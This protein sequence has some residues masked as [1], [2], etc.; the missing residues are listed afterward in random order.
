MKSFKTYGLLGLLTICALGLFKL[1][2]TQESELA[3]KED[4]A[5]VIQRVKK[6]PRKNSLP[7]LTEKAP[8]NVKE[9]PIHRDRDRDRE[10]LS[11]QYSNIL[12][13]I[14]QG[15][16]DVDAR[17]ESGMTL[18]MQALDYHR[19]QLAYALVKRGADLLSSDKSG[20]DILTQA[21][22]MGETKITQMALENGA[23][24]N[25]ELDKIGS[26]L[27]M[28]AA[29]EGLNEQVKLLIEY[30][31]A[32]NHQNQKGETALMWASDMG[33]FQTAQLLI[34]NK[35]DKSLKNHNALT[36]MEMAKNRG[37]EKLAKLL[38]P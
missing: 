25:K 24:P 31:A 21:L 10:I 34:K 22:L 38:K 16:L 14:D 15:E 35:A 3:P 30:G 17:D 20:T 8:N 13:R 1:R 29:Q 26:A 28:Y 37:L 36:A 12:K 2:S 4:R 5:P 6:R 23:D 19:P 9:E 32:V 11:G 18:L 27:L 7:P 33:Q